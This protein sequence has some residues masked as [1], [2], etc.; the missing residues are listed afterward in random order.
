[1]RRSAGFTLIELLVV[2]AII[3]LLMALL[4]PAVQAARRAAAVTQCANNLHQLGLAIL[5]YCENN[6]GHFPQVTHASGKEEDSWVY[7]LVPYL[8][9]ISRAPDAQNP[10]LQ[11]ELIDRI[12]ICPAD[13]LGDKRLAAKGTSYKLNEFLT[14]P[15]LDQWG[16]PVADDP[17]RFVLRKIKATSQTIVVFTAA[18]NFKKLV[19]PNGDVLT[20]HAGVGPL[21]DHTHSRNWLTGPPATWWKKVTSDVQPDRHWSSDEEDHMD[22]ISNYLYVDGHVEK[23]S[24]HLF[25]EQIDRGENPAWPR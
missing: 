19:L 5:M 24:P 15:L 8:G 18:D 1:M 7:G 20:T 4:L 9:G 3:G 22:G 21:D 13:P 2:I 14:V 6:G 16:R 11:Y 12:R 10:Q 25:R 17:G 23:M